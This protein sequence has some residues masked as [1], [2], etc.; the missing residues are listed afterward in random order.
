MRCVEGRARPR[1]T[2][3]AR[4]ISPS[5]EAGSKYLYLRGASRTG[6]PPYG[7]SEVAAE[8]IDSRRELLLVEGLLD[9]HHL[10]AR[11]IANVAALG[12]TALAPEV[13]QLLAGRGVET[14]TLCLDRDEPGRRATSASSRPPRRPTRRADPR[15]RPLNVSLPRTTPTRPGP[16]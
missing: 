8:P 2:F 4:D 11:G 6:L 12:G 9:V 13:L 15:R 16:N 1:P 3:W 10:R 14:V 7:W 5:P